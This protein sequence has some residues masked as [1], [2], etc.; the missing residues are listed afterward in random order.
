MHTPTIV[1]SGHI[2]VAVALISFFLK[3]CNDIP[4]TPHEPGPP[5]V[6]FNTGNGL[7]HTNMIRGIAVDFLGKA[8]IATDSGAYAYFGGAWE[9]YRDSIVARNF[10][11]QIVTSVAVGG[12]RSAWFGLMGGGVIRIDRESS[13]G[14]VKRYTELDGLA[15]DVV[16]SVTSD[17]TL[18]GEIYCA[19]LYGVSRFTPNR[20]SVGTTSEGSW[21]TYNN[22]NSSLPTNL[23]RS[24]AGNYI[25]NT[26]WFGTHDAG[27]VSYDGGHLWI[28]YPLPDA[29]QSPIVSIAFDNSGTVWFGKWD[30]VSALDARTAVWKRHYTFE[31]TGGKLPPGIVNAVATD[32]QQ[33]RWFGTRRGL[34]QLRDTTWSTFHPGN[35]PLPSD[36]VTTLF[37]DIV[38]HNLWIG[39]STG[40][41]VYNENGVLF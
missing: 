35:S 10:G 37:Y 40:A 36:T 5:W 2:I 41:A 12:M 32:G 3:A 23:I 22:Q 21:K 17:G 7:L 27:A 28:Q 29:Y 19:G 8:W 34:V 4:Q 14:I 9:L 16:L 18:L 25:D 1:R 13:F 30:G 38:S 20:I 33:T 39:T 31:T 24:V 6:V 11:L 26:I 15:N